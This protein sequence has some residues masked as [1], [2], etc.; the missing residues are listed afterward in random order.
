[1]NKTNL[2]EELLNIKKIELEFDIDEDSCDKI[3][4]CYVTNGDDD[5]LFVTYLD[6]N[7]QNGGY[8]DEYEDEDYDDYDEEEIEKRNVPYVAFCFMEDSLK[9]YKLNKEFFDQY[10]EGIGAELDN[11]ESGERR[12]VFSFYLDMSPSVK[13]LKTITKELI[14]AMKKANLKSPFI[15]NEE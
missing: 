8:G 6:F 2:N 15:H 9:L 1:M 11:E 13:S 4:N 5:E 3:I 10:F 12:I 14:L 7:K